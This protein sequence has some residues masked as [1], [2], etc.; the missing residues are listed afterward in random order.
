MSCHSGRETGFIAEGWEIPGEDCDVE[1]VTSFGA[2]SG[3]ESTR[4]S[5]AS[6]NTRFAETKHWLKVQF[7][8]GWLWAGASIAKAVPVGEEI[9]VR[10]GMSSVIGLITGY[11]TPRW[12]GADG[13]PPPR[14]SMSMVGVTAR[15]R[16]SSAA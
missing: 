3:H 12:G 16:T 9:S 7:V 15:M 13:G 1:E 11:S 8:H 10:L 2:E 6:T 14:A 5:T 4:L